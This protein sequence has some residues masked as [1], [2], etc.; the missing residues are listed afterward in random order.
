[1]RWN[2]AVDE[3]VCFG[4]MDS[5]KTIENFVYKT[6]LHLYSFPRSPRSP[7]F[8]ASLKKMFLCTGSKSG[9]FAQQRK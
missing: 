6:R 5:T 9:D 4:W 1:M 8:Q 3:T 2:E 7:D